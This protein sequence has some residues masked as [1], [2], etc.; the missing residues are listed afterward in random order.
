MGGWGEVRCGCA[1]GKSEGG[2]FREGCGHGDD[3]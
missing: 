2:D 3:W 1:A